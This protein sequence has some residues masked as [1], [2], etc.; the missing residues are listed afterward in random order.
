[1]NLDQV[2]KTVNEVCDTFDAVYEDYII[3]L[4]GY[5]GMHLLKKHNLVEACGVA[6]GRQL[7]VLRD[8]PA[9]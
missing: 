6:H 7:C 2:Y 1:M 5:E 9:S 4:V 8:K 3:Y